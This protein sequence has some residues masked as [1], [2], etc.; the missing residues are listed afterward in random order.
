MAIGLKSGD[1][2]DLSKKFTIFLKIEKK[3]IKQFKKIV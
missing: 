3:K 2:K 1:P